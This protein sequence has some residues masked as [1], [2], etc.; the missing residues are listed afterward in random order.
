MVL[1]ADFVERATFDLILDYCA[2]PSHVLCGE[3]R[4]AGGQA[5]ISDL[6]EADAAVM[7]RSRDTQVDVARAILQQLAMP[8]LHGIQIDTTPAAIVERLGDRILNRILRPD[9][10]IEPAFD[11]TQRAQQHDVF[12]VLRVGD[13]LHGAQLT[14]IAGGTQALPMNW[15]RLALAT[16]KIRA[17]SRHS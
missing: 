3:I 14:S 12:A 10:D 9:I 17:R 2:P 4:I 1:F 16:V 6:V 15:G 5:G 7:I 13:E 8:V 11:M